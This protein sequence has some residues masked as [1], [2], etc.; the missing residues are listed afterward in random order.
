MP[1]FDIPTLFLVTAITA[2]VLMAALVAIWLLLPESASL[3]DWAVAA[4]LMTI[5]A[6]L[7]G[8]RKSA[9]PLFSIALANTLLIIGVGQIH[10]AVRVLL[11]QARGWPWQWLAGAACFGGTA[12]FLFVAPSL[13]VRILIVSLLFVPFL[14][15]SAW[16][17]W[18]YGDA[19]MPFVHRF[20]GLLFA[21]GAVMFLMRAASAP[22]ADVS[23][24]Y[25]ATS[26]F[27]VVV[28]NLYF[29]VIGVWLAVTLP[30]CI[31]A[32]LQSQLAVARNEAEAASRAKSAFLSTV[33]HEM[34]APMKDVLAFAQVLEY[35]RDLNR[36]Q[37]E[38]VKE[39]AGGGRRLVEIVDE[40][41]DLARIEAGSLDLAVE[42]VPLDQLVEDCRG[43]LQPLLDAA[44][45]AFAA[46]VDAGAAARADRLRLRQVL[47][48]LLAGAIRCNRAGDTVVVTVPPP[49]GGRV[50]IAIS[51]SGNGIAAERMAE[52]FQPFGRLR[53]DNAGAPGPA[54]GLAVTRSLVRLMGGEIGITSQVGIGATAW[55]DLPAAP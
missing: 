43:Q 29:I 14:G 2:A 53:G 26:S 41:L 36:R 48:N 23:P 9:H 11:G 13:P 34:R 51:D 45:V 5:G 21:L 25:T 39:I 50:R 40:M 47:L 20:T 44:G 19:D 37:Q 22:G 32:R 3:R 28:P 31:S 35:D 49:V 33:A 10:V 16:L 46:E 17:F 54:I 1:S 7:I 15:T 38:C 27:I 55:I 8:M 30:L 18:R 12:W 24:D 52:L 4:I 42:A 6:L